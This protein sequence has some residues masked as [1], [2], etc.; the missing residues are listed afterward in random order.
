[1][2]ELTHWEYIRAVIAK[3]IVVNIAARIS[4]FAVLHLIL[5]TSELYHQKLTEEM[6]AVE[7]NE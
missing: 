4:S 3:W 7:P 2:E 6:E 1:M 5:E